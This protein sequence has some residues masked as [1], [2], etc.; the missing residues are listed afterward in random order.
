SLRRRHGPREHVGVDIARRAGRVRLPQPAQRG[1]APPA[2]VVRAAGRGVPR[3]VVAAR[4]RGADR[5]RRGGAAHPSPGPRPHAVRVLDAVHVPARRGAAGGRTV[6]GGRDRHRILGLLT[7]GPDGDDVFVAPTPGDG[8]GR[9]FGGQV[10]SQSLRAA[11]LTVPDG[12]PPHS[13]HAY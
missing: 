9:L 5:G 6:S 2:R 1:D 10:A 7:L 3:A 8:P 12:R 4:G 13:L 11:T